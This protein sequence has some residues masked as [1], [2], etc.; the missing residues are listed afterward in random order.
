MGNIEIQIM[1]LIFRREEF[2]WN[3]NLEAFPSFSCRNRKYLLDIIYF[4]DN[5]ADRKTTCHK[6]QQWSRTRLKSQ[7]K[8]FSRS[9]VSHNIWI[10]P[11]LFYV[12]LRQ[13][14][15]I[16]DYFLTNT[17]YCQSYWIMENSGPKC[18]KYKRRHY[19]QIRSIFI[20]F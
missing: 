16:M 12:L 8:M 15:P 9:V 18:L 2:N 13:L 11:R 4:F 10:L 5:N 20:P 19:R 17:I 7:C 3:C 1:R 14:V 6:I